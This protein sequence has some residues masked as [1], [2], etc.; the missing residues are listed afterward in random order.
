[1]T[2]IAPSSESVLQKKRTRRE[3]DSI[4]SFVQ[5]IALFITTRVVHFGFTSFV[6]GEKPYKCPRCP[7]AAPR[8]D[9]I[10]R[11]MRIHSK[12][13]SRRGRRPTAS[14][15]PASTSS[16]SLPETDAPPRQESNSSQDSGVD[17]QRR[18]ASLS[19]TDSLESELSPLP[20]TSLTSSESL[21]S[22]LSVKAPRHWSMTSLESLES[23][24]SPSVSSSRHHSAR[25]SSTTSGEY[26]DS[27][28]SP[29]KPRQSWSTLS[30]DL[31]TA[32]LS[33]LRHDSRSI[34]M[35]SIESAETDVTHLSA[36]TS[37]GSGSPADMR[38]CFERCTVAS[39][40][41]SISDKTLS[42]SPPEGSATPREGST[43]SSKSENGSN[44]DEVSNGN[45]EITA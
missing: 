23:S 33:P 13:C 9:M 31:D 40:Q 8:R 20:R 36:A 5:K 30:T 16:T 34:S 2:L 38:H 18:N 37:Q 7:Y 22:D 12:Q 1:M 28:Q 25:L 43:P 11:H 29:L 15:A 26:S 45:Q 4:L 10:T 19:S 6:A 24:D 17:P 44:K 3:R 27:L 21:D 41:S 35:A 42:A 39:D 32:L 14:S